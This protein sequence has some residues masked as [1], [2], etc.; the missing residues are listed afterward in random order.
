MFRL[1]PVGE[2]VVEVCTN[3]S[4][5]LAGAQQVVEAFE[6]ELG[7]RRPARRRGRRVHAARRSSASAAAA[8]RRSSRS[9]TA[10]GC[11]CRPRTCPGSSRSS[12]DRMGRG[13]GR[14]RCRRLRSSSPARNG[15]ALTAIA[16]YEAVGG[17]AALAQGAR[18][19][20]RR[21]DRG[22]RAPPACAAAAARAS[23]RAASGASSRSRTSSTKPHYL[24]VNADES[25][26]GTFKDREIML[27][28][29]FRFLE[30]CAH[31]RPRDR[32]EARLRLH[33][34]RVRGRVRGARRRARADAGEA[35]S[36]ATSRS[37]S[38]AAP[39]P[40]SAARRRRCSS[41][42]RASAASRARSRRSRRS[43]ASTPRRPRSTTSRRS[44]PRPPILEIGGAEYA[45]LGVENS[46]GTRVFSLSGNVVNG[47][48]LRARR[49]ASRC[50]S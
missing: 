44:R 46:T 20:P 28:V 6:R 48:Q 35:A 27:R 50:A 17:F 29:P 12:A 39:A 43:P 24:V 7:A 26:P 16:D 30:G 41:R 34:R 31:R 21:R 38:T 14:G 45:K 9:T 10:T 37:S 23:R 36:S 1:E 8:G 4:C 15:G 25:E 19:D 11:T 22:A 5:G 42:S 3:V 40:T 13:G 33:P 49:T 18:A 32:V 47:R 2:H